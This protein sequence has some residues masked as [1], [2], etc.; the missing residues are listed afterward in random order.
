M[1]TEKKNYGAM[2]NQSVVPVNQGMEDDVDIGN[3]V[4]KLGFLQKFCFM[5]CL[6]GLLGLC[7][8]LMILALYLQEL[9][10]KSHQI[11]PPT[12]SPSGYQPPAK[13]PV[14]WV[15]A[16][17]TIVFVVAL[18]AAMRLLIMPLIKHYP[19]LEA[20]VERPCCQK[21]R[22]GEMGEVILINDYSHSTNG[23]HPT[24]AP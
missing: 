22:A 15:A 7:G 23:S 19:S 3:S 5:F 13:N 18:V 2:L 8:G 6:T 14:Q 4:K 16:A 9:Y 21:D 10:N 24:A 11:I 12:D 20:W 1:Q 17:G